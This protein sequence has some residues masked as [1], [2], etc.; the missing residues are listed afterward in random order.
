MATLATL[1]ATRQLIELE[2]DLDP[3]G[4]QYRFLYFVPEFEEFLDRV[5]G[6]TSAWNLDQ[7]PAEQFDDLLAEFLGTEPL[8]TGWR[9]GPLRPSRDGA[10]PGVWELKT[11]DLRIFGW[12]A[13]QNYFIAVAGE[14][15][16][17]VKQHKLYPAFREAVVMR[18]N[19]LP[20]DE[21]KYITGRNY[22][23]VVSL[24]RGC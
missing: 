16:W 11:A 22:S 1:L 15:T 23:D 14:E 13:A 6:F 20:L 7:T 17:K 10:W 12:F 8:A 2:P 18:R 21:P 3:G 19:A 5:P 4:Q 24:L 9:F